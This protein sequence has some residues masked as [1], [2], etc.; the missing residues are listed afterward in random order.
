M[1]EHQQLSQLLAAGAMG[2]RDFLKLASALGLSAGALEAL[3]TQQGTALAAPADITSGLVGYWKLDEGSGTNAADSSG[4]GNNG[5]LSGGPAWTTGKI[6]TA[7]SFN[8]GTGV[9]IHRSVL[10]TSGSYSVAAWVQLTNIGNWSTAVSQDGTTISGFFLQYTNPGA[11]ADGGKFAFSV[12][13][14]DSTGGTSVRATSA[15]TPLANRW[16]HLVGIHDAGSNQ[17]KLYVNGTLV[18]TRSVVPAWNATG[19]TV[20]GH[21]KWGG[22]SV[23]FWPGLIDDVRVYNRVLSDQDVRDIYNAAPAITPVRPPAVPLVVRSP[24]INVWQ[25]SNAAPGTWSTFWNGNVKALTGIARIDGTAY[26]FFGAPGG[27]GTTQPMPQTQ[28]EIT[29][30]QSRYTFQAGGVA[31]NVDFLSP[32]EASDVQRLSIPFG[33]IFAQTQSIDGNAHSVSLYFDISGEW[34]HGN[35]SA[36]I[37]WSI[38]QV[39][40][41][42]GN[43]SAYA[44]RPDAPATLAESNDYPSWGSAIWATNTQSNMTYQSGPDTVVRA[45]AVSQGHLNNSMDSNMPRAINNNWPVFAFN[46]DFGSTSGQPTGQVTLV[47]G[48]VREPAVSYLGTPLSSL[49][50][51]YWSSWQ[52]MLAFAYDDTAAALNRAG[53]L[54]ASISTAA[55]AAGGAHYAALCS[56]ALRQ[57]FGGVELVGGPSGPWLLLKEISSSGNVST[58]DVIYPSSPVFFYVNSYLLRLLLDPVLAYSESGHW[59]K[60]FA[61]H[62]LG[63]SYPN[64]SGH[65]D[66][67]EEDMPIEESANMLLMVSAYLHTLSAGDAH[68]YATAHYPILK[69]WADYLVPNTLDPAFQNQTDDFTGFIAHSSNLALKGILAVGAMGQIGGFAGNSADAQYY[70]N[71][72][73]SLIGQWVTKSQDSSGQHLK[74]AYDQDGTWS[75]KYNAFFDK[76]LGLNLV[77][78]SVLQEE[79]NWYKSKE[80]PY[81]IPLDNRHTYTKADWEMWTAASTSDL[82]LRQYFINALYQFANTS[83]SRVPFTDWYETISDV[84]VGFQARP[85]IGG[86]FSIL[87]RTR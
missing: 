77:P 51:S 84:Q 58:V 9:D 73:S 12:V 32:V 72:A 10:N 29:P 69:Q 67:N 60:V 81:G 45:L 37:D 25:T 83:G 71:Q 66:G 49:W 15:F 80:N 21:A 28:L 65:N 22:G 3:L 44:V 55:V 40:H 11:G 24:Y 2:R 62:D 19:E 23:D 61:V 38:E 27:I 35:S 57:A 70:A 34:A 14:A 43:V 16:Y 76:L 50:K 52:Q 1:D 5:T 64:A 59:P 54:D 26:V 31:L 74:L 47:I 68:T 56:L 18:A 20:I 46:F 63:A 8:G 6:G 48:H 36:L 79:A 30:T 13:S 53:A 39:A 42:G 7:L 41:S 87:A 4:N 33:Y 82:A 85:V 75:L 78:T 17:I 86:L